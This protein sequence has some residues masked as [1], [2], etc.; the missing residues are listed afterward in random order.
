MDTGTFE[1]ENGTADTSGAENSVAAATDTYDENDQEVS[2]EKN[3][4][5]NCPIWREYHTFEINSVTKVNKKVFKKSLD[6]LLP[7]CLLMT[8]L[9]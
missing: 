9:T 2:E 7:V 5:G 3:R 4:Y 6:L 1:V 8:F